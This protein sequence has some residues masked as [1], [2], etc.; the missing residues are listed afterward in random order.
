M[1]AIKDIVRNGRLVRDALRGFD[2]VTQ[3]RSTSNTLAYT[4]SSQEYS[5]KVIDGTKNE[6]VVD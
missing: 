6:G 3:A 4:H 2:V 1:D 5:A